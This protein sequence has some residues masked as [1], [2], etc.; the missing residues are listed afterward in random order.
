MSGRLFYEDEYD[1]YAE[2]IGKSG[3]THKECAH[4]LWPDMKSA[5]AIAKFQNCIDRKGD[6]DFR[7]GQVLALMAFCGQYDPL[8]YACDDTLHARPDRKSPADQEQ[9]IVEVIDNAAHTM[10][11]AM[12]EL[13]SLRRIR[14]V[15]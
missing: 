15:A 8:M 7:F 11:R 5:S 13:N 14:G 10:Q 3:K 2:M 12:Q 9:R 4:F 6:E 1:A